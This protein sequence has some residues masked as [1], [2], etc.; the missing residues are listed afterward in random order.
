M[1]GDRRPNGY[2]IERS[3]YPASKY[4]RQYHLRTP[5]TLAAFGASRSTATPEQLTAREQLHVYGRGKYSVGRNWR[6]FSQGV[7]LARLGRAAVGAASNMIGRVVG[8]GAYGNSLMA[9]GAMTPEVPMVCSEADETGAVTVSRREFVADIYAPASGIAFENDSYALNPGLERT[10]PWLSQIAQNYEEYSFEQLIFH[11]RSVVTDVGSSTTGQCGSVIMCT[12]YN[13]ASPEFTDKVAMQ[14]YDGAMSC[15]TTESMTHGV[16]C[17]DS[18]RAGFDAHYVRVTPVPSGQ[19]PKTYDH[20]VFQLAVANT[21]TGYANQAIGELWVS[22]TVKLAKPKFSVARGLGIGRD[23]FVSGG[24]ESNSSPL[25]ALTSLLSGQM[26]SIG[27]SV[28]YPATPDGRIGVAIPP[29]YAGTLEVK[30]FWE[31]SAGGTEPIT[32]DLVFTGNVSGLVDMYAAGAAGDTPAYASTPAAQAGGVVTRGCAVWHI[33]VS[34]STGGI[35]NSFTIATAFTGA[36]G[37]T[38]LDIMEYNAGFSS[39]ALGIGPTAFRSDAPIL[40]SPQGV[41]V[42]PS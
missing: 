35:L 15:K 37:Q 36:P 40:V 21:P 31:V 26:N 7:G 8:S 14:A 4:M 13:V 6:K 39:R 18:K 16:E 38:A 32:R 41:Q 5:Q 19:D 27:C 3:R 1:A 10:F 28:S 9:G 42:V 34:P 22:Y 29:E 30:F 25:G 11:Y 12:T 24:S 2:T 17:D 23:L 20:G 33:R